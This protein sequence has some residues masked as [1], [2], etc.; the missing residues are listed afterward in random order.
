MAVDAVAVVREAAEALERG[1]VD[2]AIA[3]FAPPPPGEDVVGFFRGAWIETLDELVGSPRRITEVRTL[4]SPFVARVLV[5]GER[6]TAA[7]TIT[8]D[9]ERRLRGFAVTEDAADGISNIVIG[10]PR[11]EWRNDRVEGEPRQLGEFYGELLGMKIIRDDWIKIAKGRGRR[12]Q[13]AFGDGWSDERPPRWPDP[14]FPQQLHLDVRVRDLDAV[15]GKVLAL[16]ATLLQDRGDFRTYADPVGHPFCL[17]PDASLAEDT[18]LWR[19]VIDCA[20]PEASARFWNGL[21]GPPTRLPELAFQQAEFVPP[22]W[23]DPAYPAMV[24]F[25]ATFDDAA[26]ARARAESL[27]A[28]RLTERERYPVYA[29]P[30]GHPFCLGTLGQ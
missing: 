7:A 27:G 1:D 12:P 21:L 9:E 25:D 6:G 24:H 3:A 28:T 13:L 4:A 17:Y 16:G 22:R 11:G 19:V 18:Q 29:D 15:A 14:E 2:G 23:P 20:D 8:I 26:A 10:C 30:D 5:E